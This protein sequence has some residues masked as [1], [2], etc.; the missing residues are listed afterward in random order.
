M[1]LDTTRRLNQ[2]LHPRLRPRPCPRLRMTALVAALLVL[3]A[4]ASGCGLESASAFQPSVSPGS[5]KPVKSLKGVTVAVGSKDFTEQIILGKI[6]VLALTAAGADVVD[7]TNIK[8]SVNSRR[9]QERGDVDLAWEYTG[10]AWITYLGQTKPIP[11]AGK[12]YRAVR[13]LDQRK[14][15]LV[16]LPPARFDNTY[17]FATTK[18]KAARLGITKMS[19]LAGLSKDE[20]TFCVESEFANRDD[21]LRPALGTYNLKIGPNVPRGNIKTMDTGVIYSQI[22]R[23]SVCTFGEVFTTD[24]RI[25][26]LGLSVL[27]D[28]RHFFPVYNPSVVVRG[29]LLAKHPELRGIFDKISQQLDTK[30]MQRLNAEVDVKGSEPSLVAKQW[31]V[32]EGFLS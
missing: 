9:A 1:S 32:D 26:A 23:G 18:Q 25:P 12:Q 2:R 8:G 27:K 20:L 6:A 4:G 30:T 17:A 24:G 21:G 31:L 16:W 22:D 15:N 19:Q 28:D 3:A 13:D 5:I 29:D 7:K 11:D 14:N 10:T